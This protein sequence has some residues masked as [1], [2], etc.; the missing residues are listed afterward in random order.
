MRDPNPWRN[1][2]NDQRVPI[3][4]PD[5]TV[6]MQGDGTGVSGADSPVEQQPLEDPIDMIFGW[7]FESLIGKLERFIEQFVAHFIVHDQ[8]VQGVHNRGNA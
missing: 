2:P 7:G 8:I 3:G 1:D 5:A 6:S 4:P